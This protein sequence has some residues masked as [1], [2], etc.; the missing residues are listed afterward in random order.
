MKHG[1]TIK[2]LTDLVGKQSPLLYG[3]YGRDIKEIVDSELKKIG[4]PDFDF[5]W[6][7]CKV[8]ILG[9]IAGVRD[10]RKRRR[11]EGSSRK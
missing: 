1:Q 6:L 7:I 5:S 11:G 3:V 9:T 10:E 4:D 8:F 2:S